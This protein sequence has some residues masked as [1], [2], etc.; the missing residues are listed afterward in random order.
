ML[1]HTGKTL[2]MNFPW[3]E[4]RNSFL[5][6]GKLLR[7]VSTHPDWT[8]DD[9]HLFWLYQII[10]NYKPNS[11]LEIGSYKGYSTQVFLVAL[12]QAF[13]NQLTLVDLNPT[14]ELQSILRNYNANIVPYWGNSLEFIKT[15]RKFDLALVDGSHLPEYTI[16]EVNYLVQNN[17]PIICLHDTNLCNL[18]WWAEHSGPSQSKKLLKDYTC[19]EDCLKRENEQTERGFLVAVKNSTPLDEELFEIIKQKSLEEI[20]S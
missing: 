20:Q 18:E 3:N 13:I 10:I 9:R 11:C 1:F 8:I 15:N 19:F 5:D 12:K 14:Q 7:S 4:F 17:T 6:R 2:C 16:P